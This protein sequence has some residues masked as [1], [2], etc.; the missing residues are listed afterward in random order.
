MSSADNITTAN[1][2]PNVISINVRTLNHGEYTY[3]ISRDEPN[4]MAALKARVEASTGVG[5]GVGRQRLLWR[6]REVEGD[7]SVD[8][9][10]WGE[11]EVV[12]LHLAGAIE[13][14]C[15]WR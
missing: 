10:G 13:G 7:G 1:T 11:M 14:M 12:T 4:V 9:L 8:E 5:V 3:A 2:I 6:G 15:L